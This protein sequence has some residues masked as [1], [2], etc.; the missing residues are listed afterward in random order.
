V[1]SRVSVHVRQ[2]GNVVQHESV[3]SVG[4]DFKSLTMGSFFQAHLSTTQLGKMFSS[5]IKLNPV[6]TTKLKT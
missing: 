3:A 4:S 2:E 1:A 6:Y 5:N